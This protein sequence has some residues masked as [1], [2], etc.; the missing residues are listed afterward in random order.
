[1]K[2]LAQFVCLIAVV[3]GLA[4][5]QL[6]YFDQGSYQTIPPGATTSAGPAVTVASK[7]VPAGN[8][9]L[10]AT[11]NG[12]SYAPNSGAVCFFT[13][14]STPNGSNWTTVDTSS[15]WTH[16]Q[17]ASV[18]MLGAYTS[19]VGGKVTVS[20]QKGYTFT[21]TS[22]FQATLSIISVSSLQ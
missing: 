6:G 2:K 16:L 18:V 21:G 12:Q 19:T 1:V 9:M 8:Y 15:D 4:F 22:Q 10:F 14:P 3:S 13:N 20:C 11:V 17:K 5:A 7:D